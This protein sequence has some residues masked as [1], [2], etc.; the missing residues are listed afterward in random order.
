M[1]KTAIIAILRIVLTAVIVF[2]F[3]YLIRRIW[4]KSKRGI[5]QKLL[6]VIL[7]VY[8]VSVLVIT[9]VTRSYD[10]QTGVILN[11]TWAY[12]QIFDTIAAGYEAGGLLEAVKRIHWVRG[13]ISSLILNVF[14]FV[15]LG[16]LLPLCFA[17]MRRWWKVL[18]IGILF[19]LCIETIQFTTHLGWFDIADQYTMGSAA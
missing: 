5:I 19:S 1:P 18:L 4:S 2:G 12:R 17:R 15:P 9:L 6:L 3:P 10:E 13:T 8:I 11:L 16:Y 7:A 14:L